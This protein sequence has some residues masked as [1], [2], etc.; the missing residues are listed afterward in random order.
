MGWRGQKS[1]SHSGSR[2]TA[3]DPGTNDSYQSANPESAVGRPRKDS[4]SEG[5]SGTT[6]TDSG[7]ND[8]YQTSPRRSSLVSAVGRPDSCKNSASQ[9]GPGSQ[10]AGYRPAV[11]SS[12]PELRLLSGPRVKKTSRLQWLSDLIN[13]NR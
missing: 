5:G 10:Y 1:T 4:A 11:E 6:T 12:E 2:T 9:G 7:T 13:L 8:T 3:T